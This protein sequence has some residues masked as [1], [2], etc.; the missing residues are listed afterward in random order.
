MRWREFW[1]EY[2]GLVFPLNAIVIDLNCLRFLARLGN[3]RM[4]QIV[5]AKDA[6]VVCL[7]LVLIPLRWRHIRAAPEPYAVGEDLGAEGLALGGYALPRQCSN[8]EIGLW[9]RL[10]RSVVLVTILSMILDSSLMLMLQK[11]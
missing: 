11:S 7:A 2:Q 9:N 8:S 5:S 3:W 6:A 10:P 4:L 1:R